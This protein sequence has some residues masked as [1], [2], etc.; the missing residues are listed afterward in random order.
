[1]R[2]KELTR[3]PGLFIPIP[4]INAPQNHIPGF[5]SPFLPTT[6][7][8]TYALFPKFLPLLSRF[9]QPNESWNPNPP[10]LSNFSVATVARSY[11]APPTA[12]S[13]TSAATPEFSPLIVPFPFQVRS[14]SVRSSPSLPFCIHR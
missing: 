5:S 2:K 6:K 9:F 7:E 10:T 13:V 8:R 11:L 1:M 14:F 4:P 12:N 3:G